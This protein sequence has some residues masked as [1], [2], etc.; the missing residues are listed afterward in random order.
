MASKISKTFP[1]TGA[2]TNF[3]REILCE[4]KKGQVV[5]FINQHLFEGQVLEQ[6]S[7]STLAS[8]YENREMRV[9]TGRITG[10]EIQKSF[11][12]SAL[13]GYVEAIPG[14]G[15]AV[16]VINAL[17]HALGY[18]LANQE[19]QALGETEDLE[20]DINNISAPTARNAFRPAVDCAIHYNHMIGSLLSIVPLLKPLV[21]LGQGIAH[22]IVERRFCAEE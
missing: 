9:K 12:W 11:S 4:H 1:M 6:K 7:F 18:Y 5:S 10:C 19:L 20:G 21:R 17:G 15:T 2:Y 8:L 14:I 16:A 3:C 13:L 22:H